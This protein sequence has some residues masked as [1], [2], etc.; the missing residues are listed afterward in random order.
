MLLPISGRTLPSV[1]IRPARGLRFRRVKSGTGP[2]RLMDEGAI[3]FGPFRLLAAQRLLLE[4]DEPVRLGSRAFD[5]LA[6]L[7]ERAATA[8]RRGRPFWALSGRT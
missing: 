5:I 2:C 1:D 8:E 7:V 3:S 6:T 4:G